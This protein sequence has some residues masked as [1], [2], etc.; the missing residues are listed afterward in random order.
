MDKL[1]ITLIQTYNVHI[2]IHFVMWFVVSYMKET[3]RMC[4]RLSWFFRLYDSNHAEQTFSA[5]V[6]GRSY[7]H[8]KST[9]NHRLGRG[10]HLERALTHQHGQKTALL[11]ARAWIFTSILWT[12]SVSMMILI[13]DFYS[14]FL[15]QKDWQVMFER[16]L[17]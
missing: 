15:N 11:D 10:L 14:L 6:G 7:P 8:A 1:C 2:C 12:K 3:Y 5:C 17:N 9:E 13:S 4:L 16:G